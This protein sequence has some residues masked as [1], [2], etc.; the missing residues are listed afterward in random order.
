[1]QL[2]II[3]TDLMN[4]RAW[5]AKAMGWIQGMVMEISLRS[6]INGI[7]YGANTG[8]GPKTEYEIVSSHL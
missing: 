8:T 6:R 4:Q 3:F 2:Q 1:M 7:M 5:L